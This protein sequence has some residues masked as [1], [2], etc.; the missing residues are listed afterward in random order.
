MDSH[1]ISHD[2]ITTTSAACS[3]TCGRPAP[4]WT[5]ASCCASPR[6]LASAGALPLLGCGE[7]EP[8]ARQA[9]T[10]TGTSTA[11]VP[12]RAA[13]R[14]PQ[15]TRA[16]SRRRVERSERAGDRHR[17]QRHPVQLRRPVRHRRRRAARRSCSRSFGLDV[18]DARGAAVYIWQ[19]DRLGRYSLY[20]RASRARTT[21]AVCRRPT[22]NGRVTFTSIFP[23]ATRAAGR[24]S[25]S[26]CIPSLRRDSVSNK[27]ATSQIALPKAACDAVYATAG[28]EASV[29]NLGRVSLATDNV[30]SDGSALELAT[31]T[32]SVGGGLTAALTVAI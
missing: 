17:A 26:R 21:C 27:V 31:I 13:R 2:E 4:G 7:L 3:A 11:A 8:D 24:T 22:P 10:G 18:R 25:T 19:C 5:E 15:E 14:I 1:R 12:G 23:A 20:S 6:D 9:D 28:Y 29:T 32:G 16:R 30:F